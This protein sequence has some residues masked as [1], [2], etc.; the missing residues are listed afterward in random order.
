MTTEFTQLNL[1]PQIMQ[2]VTEL[3]Y[4]EPTPI[5]SGIIPLMLE[6]RDALGQA[7]TGTGKTAAF[8][9]P[10]L[11]NIEPGRGHVQALI[12]APTRELALQVSKA[13]YAYGRYRQIRVLSIYGGQPYGRQINRLK[14]GVDVVVGTPGRLLD[15]IKRKA[16]DLS[17]VQTVVLD[18][19]DEMLSMGF[20]EDIEAILDATAPERQTALFSATLPGRIRHLADKYMRDPQAV[21]V[22]R[23]QL[24]VAAIE[25]RYYLV[26]ARDKLAALTRLFE[27]EE[28]GSTLIFARTRLGTG[29]LANELTVRGF[30]AEA[31]NGDLSQDARERVM[32]RFRRGQIQVLVAT[33]VAARGLDID[34][35]SHVFNYDL[36]QDSEV[37]VHRIGRTGRAGKTGIAITLLTPQEQWR[38]RRIERYAG[39][40]VEKTALPTVE[41]IQ[42]RREAQLVEQMTVWLKRDR[43]RREREMVAQLA[44]AGY[45]MVDIAAA[46]LKLARAE[47]KQRPIPRLAEVSEREFRPRNG[48]RGHRNENGRH[49]G[50]GRYNGNGNNRNRS[51]GRF[52]SKKSHE[53]GM[54]RLQLNAGKEQGVRPNDVV[55]TI[56]FHADIPGRSIGAIRIQP[57]YTWVDVPEQFAAQVL[58]KSGSYQI[59]RQAVEVQ[60]A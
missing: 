29:E 45:D 16:L 25:Q 8:S 37:Y 9:L 40:K 30:P 44:E 20:I 1:H 42:A 13:I 2:A 39:S 46:A 36:P 33:D 59:H 17:Q 26:N 38:L 53:N 27:M 58:D 12:M 21:T 31:L 4:T 56:A 14:K 43:A 15:L 22:K 60:R 49:N 55:G 18:E 54:V 32:N 10:I 11:H 28:M 35:I 41:D 23:K 51:Q 5:Q 3:G 6:G 57:E 50:N 47:E 34:D 48:R 24:T 52:Q 7:Q 19:A